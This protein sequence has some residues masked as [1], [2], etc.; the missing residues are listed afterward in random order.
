MRRGGH[1]GRAPQ[2]VAAALVLLL[3]ALSAPVA[4]AAT[5]GH[6]RVWELVTT[7]PTNG[8]NPFDAQAWGDDGTHVV[9]LSFGPMPGAPSGD[10][11]SVNLATRG[12]SGWV[13]QPIGEPFSQPSLE[14][15]ASQ[16]VAVDASFASWVWRA[17]QPLLPDAPPAPQD[18]FYRRA[19][20]GALTLLGPVGNVGE[21]QFVAASADAQH[22]VFQST[23]HLLPADA[24]RVA[25][26]DA[27]EFAGSELRLLGVD[28]AGAPLSACGSVIGNGSLQDD[29][30]THPVSRDG[31]RI[32]VSAPATSDCGTPMRVY[33]RGNG[34]QTVEASASACTR[35]DCSAPTD[36]HFAGAT[37][38]GS[39]AFLLTA[40][41]LTDDDVDAGVD[42]Y[43]YDVAGH[44][45]TRLSAG[46]PGV[47]ADVAGSVV[48]ISEE[49]ARVWFVASGVLVPGEGEAGHP[50]LYLSDHGTLHFVATADDVD[51]QQATV[52]ADGRVL[53]F[54]TTVQLLP[55]DSDGQL[56]VYRYDAQLGSLQ[57]VTLGDGGR[58][59]GLFFV[60]FAL[61]G[62]FHPLQQDHVRYMSAD[63]R[64]VL[65]VTS[66]PL[67]AEDVN[68]TP[69]VYEWADGTLGLVSSGRGDATVVYRGLSADGSSAFFTTDE[70]LV[71]ADR[72]G[73]DVDLYAARLGGGFPD[74]PPAP[75]PCAD[76][77]CQGPPGARLERPTLDTLLHVAAPAGPR[78]H[79]LGRRARARLAGTG[80]A[81]VVADVFAAGRVSLLVRALV[82]GRRLVVARDTADPRSAGPVRLHVQLSAAAGRLLRSGR[83]L[84]LT[85][86]VRQADQKAA[87]SLVARLRG[88]P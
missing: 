26:S 31:T 34:T 47:S 16:P 48:A 57:Q 37:R 85:L 83:P 15:R 54:V 67:V 49:G 82:D 73:G 45:L 23:A 80:R 40:Q 72:N 24:G 3:V 2:L 62:V 4:R 14:V 70:T 59:N 66:E 75:P 8:V 9:Y 1:T 32:W 27:Y 60:V 44:T 36:V 56:D 64:R 29:V 13:K 52:S 63:G 20:D 84:R 86:I 22:A 17:D 55:S 79:R 46:P 77:A 69:D 88:K 7:G 25:G 65:F 78:I 6:G 53:A 33:L 42:L 10:L 5:P 68:E 50:N 43:R 30:L 39:A 12:P 21:S 71:S 38:D 28:A 51:L 76:D 18:A 11:A 81:I 87:L 74:A 61:P 35:P 58:G 19:P 41:Q